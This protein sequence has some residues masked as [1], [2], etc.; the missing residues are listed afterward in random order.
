MTHAQTA[1]S[2]VVLASSGGTYLW[3]RAEKL[4][5]GII[6]FQHRLRTGYYRR[7]NPNAPCPSC[8]ARDG[9]IFYSSE[10]QRVVHTCHVDQ[11]MWCEMPRIPAKGWDFAGRDLKL[12]GDHKED[13]RE[14]LV[15]AN[16]P[17]VPK[18]EEKK[19]ETVQ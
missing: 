4:L 5:D 9:E 1:I 6:R 14:M 2:L 3:F 19:A 18:S 11:A 17:I 12:A 16:R 15:R 8:R 13:I 7:I 10:L